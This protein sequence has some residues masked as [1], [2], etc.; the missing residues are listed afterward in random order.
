MYRPTNDCIINKV[1]LQ[2]QTQHRHILKWNCIWVSFWHPQI[3]ATECVFMLATTSW[4]GFPLVE[5]LVAS[6]YVGYYLQTWDIAFMISILGQGCN[7]QLW[8]FGQLKPEGPQSLLPVIRK[9]FAGRGSIF[10]FV[11][12][13]WVKTW[14]TFPC[15][16]QDPQFFFYR[17][18]YR[19]GTEAG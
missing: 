1:R 12:R 17:S 8:S 16:E 11:I 9:A 7:M 10:A 5:M 15:F 13:L 3:R 19:L 14:H 2:L 4:K 18:N 6:H